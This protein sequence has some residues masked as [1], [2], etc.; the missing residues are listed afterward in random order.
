[1]GLQAPAALPEHVRVAV[2]QRPH[3]PKS[4]DV[5]ARVDG[6]FDDLARPRMPRR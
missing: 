6:S 2:Q 5:L 4:N 1:M 3:R